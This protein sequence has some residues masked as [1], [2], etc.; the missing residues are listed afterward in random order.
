M[1]DDL[2]SLNAL[3]AFE[4]AAQYGSFSEAARQLH[5]THG[6]ISRQVKALESQLGLRLFQKEGRGVQ[7]TRAGQQLHASTREAFQTLRSTCQ[8]LQRQHAQAP[9]VLGCPGSL[10]A[11]WLIPRLEHLQR[12]LP[13]LRLQLSAAESSNGPF[14][15]DMDAR[16]CFA[17]PPWPQGLQVDE[18]APEYIGP[19]VSPQHPRSA[20]WQTQPP[21]SLLGE[22]LLHTISRPQA[23]PDW[24]KVQGLDSQ[25]LHY[26]QSF[27]H[28]YYLLEAALAGLGIAIAP[29]LLVADDLASGR[30]L[31]PWGFVKTRASLVLQS[32]LETKAQTQGLHQ[33][34]AHTLADSSTAGPT[35]R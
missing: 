24:A 8:Q 31:A 29:Q 16:L 1:R 26:G 34:L 18:L 27:E 13:E 7:L 25:S 33:W 2:P 30:L 19:V 15:A 28:L 3:H 17:E 4:A 23:W 12:A 32:P 20:Y 10:L 11:R 22:P 5:L 21:S 9:L 14:P 35:K 6:A